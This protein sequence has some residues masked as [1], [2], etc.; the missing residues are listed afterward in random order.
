MEQLNKTLE[1]MICKFIH[2]DEHNWDRWLDPPLFAVQEVPQAPAVFSPFELL[3]ASKSRGMLDLIKENWEVRA[4][5]KN[6]I[7]YMLNLRAKLHTLGR[8]SHGWPVFG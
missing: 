6:E 1:S 4:L 3:Y 5:K 7:Q 2:E 8:L